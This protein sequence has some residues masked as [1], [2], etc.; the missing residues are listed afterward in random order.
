MYYAERLTSGNLLE[1]DF[2]EV[3][4]RGHRAVGDRGLRRV[5]ALSEV[6]APESG[7]R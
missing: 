4:P 7:L 5:A 3:G 2:D 6:A 1:P